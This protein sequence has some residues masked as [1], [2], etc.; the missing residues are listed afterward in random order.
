MTRYKFGEILVSVGRKVFSTYYDEI[1]DICVPAE[2]YGAFDDI[3][4]VRE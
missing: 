2:K 4:A 3:L 1:A